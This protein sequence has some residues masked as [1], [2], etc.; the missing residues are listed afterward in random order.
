MWHVLQPFLT[1]QVLESCMH[2]AQQTLE[3][4]QCGQYDRALKLAQS[5][6]ERQDIETRR[7]VV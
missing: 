6:A 7:Y 3:A 1:W 2:R 5:D 4:T